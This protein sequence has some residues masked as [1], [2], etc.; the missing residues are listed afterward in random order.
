MQFSLNA[1]KYLQLKDKRDQSDFLV[2]PKH[3]NLLRF[4]SWGRKN[5][6][7]PEFDIPIWESTIDMTLT[8]QIYKT[9]KNHKFY[10]TPPTKFGTPPSENDFWK[11]YNIFAQS[12][13][14]VEH[15]KKVIK[16]QLLLYL[17]S[18]NL[19][20][21]KIYALADTD[22]S[23]FINGWINN[24]KKN[25][26]LNAHAHGIH[27][28]S[29]ISGQIILSNSILPVGFILPHLSLEYGILYCKN[30]QS[31][32]KLFPSYLPHFIPKVSQKERWTLAFDIFTEDFIKLF[33]KD[34]K[35]PQDPISRV[36]VL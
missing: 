35:N 19:I 20:G 27:E 32:L 14:F 7:A 15:L 18:L 3:K 31:A 26:F 34:I 22:R 4:K 9:V 11:S 1:G 28:H 6:F 29:F 21:G 16:E 36:V 33:K 13:S 25:E 12:H 30:K 24:M 2:T 23:F 10:R 5:W 17:D 8:K